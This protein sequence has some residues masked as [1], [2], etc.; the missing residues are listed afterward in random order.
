MVKQIMP[1][2]DTHKDPCEEN[3]HLLHGMI[4]GEYTV[5]IAARSEQGELDRIKC[6]EISL[7]EVSRVVFKGVRVSHIVNHNLKAHV[8]TVQC[9]IAHIN[10]SLVLK[11]LI[12]L[13]INACSFRFDKGQNYEVLCKATC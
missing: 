3:L 4:A 9:F 5:L 2:E 7:L 10:C 13:Y 12:C 1:T 6:S 11:R 8:F